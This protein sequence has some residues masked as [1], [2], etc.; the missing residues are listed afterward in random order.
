MM[1]LTKN[2]INW[3]IYIVVVGLFA[4][5]IARRTI[6][7]GANFRVVFQVIGATALMGYTLA[8][9]Q[10]SIWYQRGW[11]LTIKATIDGAIYAFLTA[12][13]FGFLWPR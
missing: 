11:M 2:L 12:F 9:W 7:F 5:I 4:A 13:V 3:F 10:M 1:P 8:L 6:G